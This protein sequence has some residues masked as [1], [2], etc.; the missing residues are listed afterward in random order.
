MNNEHGMSRVAVVGCPGSGKS[1]FA[2]A[3]AARTGLPLV[4]LDN[5]WWK[6]DRTHITRDAFDAALAAE[7]RKE[8][9]IIDGYYSRTVEARL[10]ACDM[11]IFLD[12]DEQTCMEGIAARVGQARS[13]IPWTEQTIDPELVALVQDFQTEHRPKLLALLDRY[14]DRDIHIFRT[15]VEADAWLQTIP[16]KEDKYHER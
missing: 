13:D 5:I 15:R 14:A 10:A 11:V 1:T 9:W 8:T 6:P 7:L 16:T 12:F 4:H 3:L 2:R